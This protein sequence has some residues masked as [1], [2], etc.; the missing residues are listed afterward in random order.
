MR[1]L[2][3]ILSGIVL[4]FQPAAALTPDPAPGVPG[5]GESQPKPKPRDPNIAD[6]PPL[7]PEEQLKT[8]HLPPGFV[9]QLV[10]A[11]PKVPKP[12][13]IAFDARGR[14]LVTGSEEYP[15]AAPAG[16]EPKD[17]VRILE[18]FDANGLARKMTIFA[19][20]LNIPIGVL[21]TDKGAIVYS[22]PNI[23]HLVDE[24]G[25]GKATRRDVLY[26]KYGFKDTHGMTG[27]FV[28]GFD[29]W[30]YCCHGYS[31]T[32]T[33]K[34]AKPQAA[35][36]ITM[37][38]G[39][40]Y[41]IKPDGSRIEY[42]THGQVNPFGLAFDP[43]GNL[44]SCDCHSRPVYQLLKGACYPSFGRPHDGLGFGPEMLTHDHGST[45]I[46]GITYYAAEHFPKEYRDNIFIGNV[47]TNRINRD[48][49]ERTGASVKG[50][51]MPDF[52][53]CDDP[54]FRPVDIKLGPDG[55]LYVAD[56]YNRI[57]G[58]YEVPLNHPGR[59]R[60]RGRIWRISYVGKDGN[61]LQPIRDLTRADVPE[62]VRDLG[63]V[64]L[65]VRIE[66]T[67]Q[68]VLRGQKAAGPVLDA[69]KTGS[70]FQQ[71]QGLWVLSRLG[72][73]S[74]ALL[75]EAIKGNEVAVRIHAMRIL[76]AQEKPNTSHRVL[77]WKGL[78]DANAMVRQA[79]A[80]A[81]GAHPNA[82]NL[83]PLLEARH[84]AGKDVYLIH[85]LRMALRDQ[86]QA[87]NFDT[88]LAASAWN[89]K[90]SRALADVC[91]GVHNGESA[92]F[93]LGHLKKFDEPQAEF[94]RFAQYIARFGKDEDVAGI[95]TITPDK[96]A[97]SLKAQGMVYRAIHQ[98]MQE[99]GKSMGQEE[100]NRIEKVATSLLAAADGEQQ[101]I[102]I[103]LAGS[104]KLAGL[105]SA[106]FQL[107]TK[108][109]VKDAQRKSAV[110]ALFIIEPQKHISEFAT[111][112]ANPKEPIEFREQVAQAL[113]GTNQP[114][115]YTALVQ[116]LQTAPARLQT[117]IALAL[118]SSAPGGE[119]LL[120]AVT[121][122]KASAR[123]LQEKGIALRLKQAKVANLDDRLAKLT[124]GLPAADERMLALLK[125]R[126]TQF[127]SAKPDAVRG[128][129]V[130]EKHCAACHQIANKGAK[131]GPQLDGIG[132]RGLDR[133]L[134][135]ILDPSRNVDQTFRAT[136]LV[137][138]NGQLV[139]GLLVRQE[140]KV[141]VMADD[142]GKEVRVAGDNVSERLTAQ[143]S[144]MPANLAEQIPAEEFH[145]LLGY[146]LEQRVKN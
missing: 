80:E 22:I 93:L 38:S 140:G 29:G 125:E 47:V 71:V 15:Y 45:A 146:L 117:S 139:T 25:K 92:T 6:T 35:G 106:L 16:R 18:D 79:A 73:L 135:D 44:Y 96:F 62:L 31:N 28:W 115:A 137:L 34:G 55:A 50:I 21:P 144:P 141:F 133:L 19:D 14:L 126:R 129:M 124:K 37:T 41:R 24:D 30:I 78:L 63:D 105:Q 68:L 130:F 114:G 107:A 46:A 120:Q 111:V 74:D 43:L 7:T 53:K 104:L 122:G 109:G 64:N 136:T 3:A 40:T 57:I 82:S 90:D 48:R 123:L 27:E 119:K 103:D 12:I 128:A 116:T 36:E 59:D 86:F 26:S 65:T 99:A 94:A 69:V 8:F 88:K 76:G 121:E 84:S 110:T 97:K 13:N 66:A 70:T 9:I 138:N 77:A 2:I 72:K 58:H 89:E 52:L 142:K 1:W 49:L 95:L 60:E 143:L 11:E 61:P 85:S 33:V 56:F 23:Y 134:E 32:S 113:A 4:F 118:A 5:E 102:G 100:R 108:T 101:Q 51:E 42:F 75:T 132:I 67:N 54:W 145:D 131:I 87:A 112:L 83:A 98:G 20:K 81:L 39:N 17:C 127:A 10:A 91:L